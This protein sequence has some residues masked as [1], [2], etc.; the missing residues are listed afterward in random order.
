MLAREDGK[1]TTTATAPA[2][3]D[4]QLFDDAIK[5]NDYAKAAS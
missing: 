1:S 5:G 2:K 4:E 3:T